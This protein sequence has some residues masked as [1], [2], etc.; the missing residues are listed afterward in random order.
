MNRFV[1]WVNRQRHNRGFGIQSPSTFF[2]ATQV[3]KERLPYYAYPLLDMIADEERSLSRRHIRELFRIT[4]HFSPKS[5]IAAGSPA[6]ACAMAAARPEAAK[7]CINE[8]VPGTIAC[9]ALEELGCPIRIGSSGTL[10][11][12][13]VEGTDGFGMLYIGKVANYAELFDIAL[14]HTNENS[15]VIVEEIHRDKAKEEWWQKIVDNPEAVIT[16][17]L[18]SYGIVLFNKERHKQHYTFKR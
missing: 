2:F 6:A 12:N 3:L 15:I 8:E 13:T 11:G 1:D 4:N 9:K 18:Y 17:D 5:I 14:R 10:L 7:H 16:Y